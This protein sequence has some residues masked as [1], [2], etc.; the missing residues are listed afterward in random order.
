MKTQPPH[1]RGTRKSTI[2]KRRSATSPRMA[3]F[4][5]RAVIAVVLLACATWIWTTAHQ[6]EWGQRAIAAIDKTLVQASLATGWRLD[7]VQV[8]GRDRV[9]SDQLQQALRVSQGDPILFYDVDTAASRVA[10]IGWVKS[11]RVTRK[12]PNALQISLEERVPVALWRQKSGRIQVVDREGVIVSPIVTP[13]FKNLLLVSGD[14]AAANLAPLLNAL[15]DAPQI[16]KRTDQAHWAGGRRWDLTLK[17]GV[18]IKLPET[19]YDAALQRVTDAQL[20]DDILNKPIDYV[21][22]RDPLRVIVKP[23]TGQA[24]DL[25]LNLAGGRQDPV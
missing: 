18:V 17:N 4:L 3:G 23:K 6:E 25:Q 12:L 24:G 16:L 10:Q 21:D 15:Q 8:T 11:V 20:R 9:S 2:L 13:A 1:R 14:D 22:V 19:M 7:R 5:R